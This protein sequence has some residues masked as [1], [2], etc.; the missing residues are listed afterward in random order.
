MFRCS[1]WHLCRSAKFAA[2]HSDSVRVERRYFELLN[3]RTFSGLLTARGVAEAYPC[4]RGPRNHGYHVTCSSS[5]TVETCTRKGAS[6]LVISTHPAFL[7]YFL[8]IFKDTA[9]GERIREE[10]P[11]AGQQL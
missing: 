9:L 3:G 7:S 10:D 11:D 2:T 5:E 6:D 8:L 4:R 1:T